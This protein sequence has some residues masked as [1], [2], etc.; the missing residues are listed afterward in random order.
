MSEEATV[1]KS[2]KNYVPIDQVAAAIN[3]ADMDQLINDGRCQVNRVAQDINAD[4]IAF[5]NLISAHYNSDPT[6]PRVEFRRGRKGGVYWLKR[7]AE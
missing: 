1:K 4:P 5:R 3:W 6:G 2:S 7:E